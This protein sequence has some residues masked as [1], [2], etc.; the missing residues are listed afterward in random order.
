MKNLKILF[1]LIALLIVA[2]VF[3]GCE[4]EEPRITGCTDKNSVN[5]NPRAN[6]N[7]GS[8]IENNPVSMNF[9]VAL[10][11]SACL[12]NCQ[13]DK[14]ISLSLT[15][16]D[17]PNFSFYDFYIET[18]EMTGVGK[19]ITIAGDYCMSVLNKKGNKETLIKKKC[20]TITQSQ[21][22]LN[23]IPDFELILEEGEVCKK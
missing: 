2:S 20:F 15:S 10:S 8:C 6:L 7:D 16:K 23:R 3:V 22:L 13:I 4:K 5:Y 12:K 11:D 17:D 9:I 1:S 21:I 19:G 18:C 14:I